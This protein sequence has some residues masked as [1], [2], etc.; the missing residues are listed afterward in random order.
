[1]FAGVASVIADIVFV[2]DALTFAPASA[3]TA[4]RSGVFGVSTPE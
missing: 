4:A 3:V 2:V 1:V